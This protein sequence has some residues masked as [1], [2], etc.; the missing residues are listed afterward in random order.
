MSVP[1]GNVLVE[2]IFISDKVLPAPVEDP[3]TWPGISPETLLASDYANKLRAM[4]SP[5]PDSYRSM[6]MESSY[7]LAPGALM[8][9]PGTSPEL[10]AIGFQMSAATPVK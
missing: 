8:L 10:V 3:T 9:L 4:S 6:M 5:I 7:R 1:D 2:N